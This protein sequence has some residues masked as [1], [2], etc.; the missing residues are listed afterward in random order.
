MLLYRAKDGKVYE[1]TYTFPPLHHGA[2]IEGSTSALLSKEN[3][4]MTS[5]EVRN[6]ANN[7][8]EAEQNLRA[9]E[10]LFPDPDEVENYDIVAGASPI[11]DLAD[12]A[13]GERAAGHENDDLVAA[14]ESFA[15]AV[16]APERFTA[17]EL[18]QQL[19]K[20][21]DAQSNAMAVDGIFVALGNCIRIQAMIGA[22]V[23]SIDAGH[24]TLI[25]AKMLVM[26]S[27][28]SL[29]NS[30]PL[31]FG[32]APSETEAAYLRLAF[33]LERAG[34]RP[35]ETNV[36]ASDQGPAVTA[37]L[38]K[39]YPNNRRMLC[40]VHIARAAQRSNRPKLNQAQLDA[41]YNVQRQPT[42][43]EFTKAFS[44]LVNTIPALTY[45]YLGE[46]PINKWAAHTFLA[47]GIPLNGL[48]TSNQAEI[49]MAW[50]R[51]NGLRRMD[52]ALCNGMF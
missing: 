9:L 37:A 17:A 36:F 1:E 52:G 13:S 12:K 43:V 18:A 38:A 5:R 24:L 51:A 29:G 48:K 40:I 41:I 14:P 11:G 35:K 30:L 45:Q 3:C 10:Q 19:H 25:N 39:A 26:S 42:E 21:S 20:F 4:V 32:I 31:A 23:L 22:N 44:A 8:P 2:L 7:A 47:A 6:V 50:C 28:C 49:V 33:F 27:T 16:A 15:A 46:L 34:F